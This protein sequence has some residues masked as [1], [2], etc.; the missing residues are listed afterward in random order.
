MDTR[1][2]VVA[3]VAVMEAVTTGGRWILLLSLCPV[4]EI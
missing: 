2:N 4:L 1:G 3:V